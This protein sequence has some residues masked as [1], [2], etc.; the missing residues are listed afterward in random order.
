MENCSSLQYEAAQRS[1]RRRRI[2]NRVVLIAVTAI[3]IAVTVPIYPRANHRLKV[4]L[5]QS[6]CMNFELPAGTVVFEPDPIKARQFKRDARYGFHS[7]GAGLMHTPLEDLHAVDPPAILTWDFHVAIAFLHSRRSPRGHLR[8]VCVTITPFEKGWHPLYAD[9]SVW[10]PATWSHARREIEAGGA[11]GELVA[12]HYARPRVLAGQVDPRDSSHFTIE[13]QWR[14][15][16]GVLDGWL[17][18]DDTVTMKLRNPLVVPDRPDETA[19][20]FSD[21]P[22]FDVPASQP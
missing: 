3:A 11:V 18:D 20:P 16:T 14:G 13:F 1:G 22:K 12:R 10:E 9:A 15:Q 4:L 19:L 8:L 2:L 17:N 6:K 5:T 21:A 7:D